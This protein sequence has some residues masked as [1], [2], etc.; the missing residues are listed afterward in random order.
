MTTVCTSIS[1][2]LVD[3][4]Y[5]T[6]DLIANNSIYIGTLN[7]YTKCLRE[8]YGA[9]TMA[10]SIN[11][12]FIEDPNAVH[13]MKIIRIRHIQND[14]LFPYDA[15]IFVEWFTKHQNDPCT[16]EDLSYI[17]NR[18]RLKQ[19]CLMYFDQDFLRKVYGSVDTQISL[20][21]EYLRVG[22]VFNY[23]RLR[24][25]PLRACVDAKTLE[26][27]KYLFNMDCQNAKALLESKPVGTWIIRRSSPHNN[28]NLM[29]NAELISM[30]CKLKS[31]SVGNAQIKSGKT[32]QQ[33]KTVHHRFLHVFGV[34]WFN[35]NNNIN[36]ASTFA[37]FRSRS[38][39]GLIESAPL[40]SC[41]IDLIDI[42][43]RDMRLSTSQL[44]TPQTD[45][46]VTVA[47]GTVPCPCRERPE[48]PERPDSC[49]T[50]TCL[51]REAPSRGVSVSCGTLAKQTI[52]QTMTQ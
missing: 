15:E 19:E 21:K 42:F 6:D 32:D 40:A 22:S 20:F 33:S 12:L 18:V 51:S 5:L 44:L 8:E 50:S 29:K 43:R 37:I 39:R 30:S 2:S 16:R 17:E 7:G 45:A 4:Q 35:A 47:A 28:K 31:D 9:F 48:L 13:P 46:V 38:N 26:C 23:P 3:D 1:N 49:R 24:K 10:D 36:N 27:G 11:K 41:L 14:E 25:L 52:Q 34:G